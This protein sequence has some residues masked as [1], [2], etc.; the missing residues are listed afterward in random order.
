MPVQ[1]V[2]H[3]TDRQIEG[4][5]PELPRHRQG[6]RLGRAETHT[7]LDGLQGQGEQLLEPVDHD[8]SA[9]HDAQQPEPFLSQVPGRGHGG[10]E[11]GSPKKWCLAKV[12]WTCRCRTHPFHGLSNSTP[13]ATKSASLRVTTV[14]RCRSAVAAIRPSTAGILSGPAMRRPHVSATSASTGR[15]RSS[16][17]AG[18][19]VSNHTLSRVRRRPSSSIMVPFR[20]SPKVRTLTNMEVCGVFRNHSE[21]RREGLGLSSSDRAQV[22]IRKLTDRYHAAVTCHVRCPVP[23]P[24]EQKLRR[25]SAIEGCGRFRRS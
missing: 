19:S 12:S 6:S 20:I 24:L 1:R 14:R 16:A 4:A 13:V 15:M 9:G 3:H 10:A 7:G 23:R 2:G 21:T 5:L 25:N 8:V 11:R 22:S 17:H 18:N